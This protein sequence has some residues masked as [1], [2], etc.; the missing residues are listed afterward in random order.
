M[1]IYPLPIETKDLLIR[2]FQDS[3]HEQT[4]PLY[5]DLELMKYIGDGKGWANAQTRN[6]HLHR[7][8][9]YFQKHG[10]GFLAVCLKDRKELIGHAVIKTLDQTDKFEVGWL[11]HPKYQGKGF[12]TQAT[13]PLIKL[14]FDQGLQE[15]FAVALE[16]NKPSLRIMEKL[17]MKNRGMGRYYNNDCV[18]YS[19]RKN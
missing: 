8:M 2:E 18:V 17:G 10:N 13:R 4:Y 15:V 6:T 5:S 11:I 7:H 9:E 16:E 14:A 19:I 3:D 1:K 12:A